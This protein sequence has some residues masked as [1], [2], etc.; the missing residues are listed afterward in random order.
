VWNHDELIR[1]NLIVFNRD[2]Q[3]WGWFD[4]KDN[5]HW[6]AEGRSGNSAGPTAETKPGDITEAHAAKTPNGQPQGL[7]L[8]N[9]RLRFEDN[10]YFAA[11]G[12]GWFK[13]GTTWARHKSYT[14]LSEFEAD[15]GVDT[16]SR[17]LDPS[18]ADLLNWISDSFRRP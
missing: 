17:V 13:W 4:V 15:L 14:D 7:T 9:L 10:F 8:E 2:A 5:R 1:H 3:L 16:G 18:F 12:H 6:P 11:P